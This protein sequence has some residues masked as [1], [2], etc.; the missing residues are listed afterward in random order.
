MIRVITAYDKLKAVYIATPKV[1]NTSIKHALMKA[2]GIAVGSNPHADEID[3]RVLQPADL[4]WSMK[5]R[6]FVFAF[7]RNPWERLVSAWADKCGPD[8]DVD[9]SHY[10]LPVG[11][12]FD[13]FV[14]TACAFND[15]YAEVHFVSQSAFLLDGGRLLPSYV[16]RFETLEHD[17]AVV[18]AA[19][20]AK[21]KIDPGKLGTMRTSRHEAYRTYYTPRLAMMVEERYAAD[22]TLFGYKF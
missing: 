14:E 7:V 17:W 16:G 9:L 11:T 22:V 13:R 8:S 3:V 19:I 6:A 12:P 2:E 18:R 21:S 20:L 15:K 10:G 1:A 5:R 4:N